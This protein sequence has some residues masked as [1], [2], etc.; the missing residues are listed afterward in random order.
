MFIRTQGRPI[1]KGWAWLRCGCGFEIPEGEVETRS[2]QTGPGL[3]PNRI[4]MGG[5]RPPRLCPTVAAQTDG[6]GEGKETGREGLEHVT[7]WG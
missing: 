5:S 2:Q 6:G 4:Q 7:W 3:F 1:P